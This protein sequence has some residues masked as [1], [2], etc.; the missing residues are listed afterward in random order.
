[1]LLK[2]TQQSLGKTLISGQSCGQNALF[3][4]EL[5]QFCGAN[6]KVRCSTFPMMILQ[7]EWPPT[8]VIELARCNHS[9][10]NWEK[11][12]QRDGHMIHLLRGKYMVVMILFLYSEGCQH[13]YERHHP[14]KD[15]GGWLVDLHFVWNHCCART[16]IFLYNLIFGCWNKGCFCCRFPTKHYNFLVECAIIG[17]P[18]FG[19][20]YVFVFISIG[21]IL[22]FVSY[23]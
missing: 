10:L 8:F 6:A 21:L 14:C 5:I 18:P 4:H 9:C 11:L 20:P 23:I 22:I 2:W 16:I 1:M 19:I 12:Q 7:E 13:K 3:T 15:V 17:R